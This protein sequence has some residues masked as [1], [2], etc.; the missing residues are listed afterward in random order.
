METVELILYKLRPNS[1]GGGYMPTR[2]RRLYAKTVEVK[3]Q[4]GGGGYMPIAN[5]Y[6][7]NSDLT[8]PV[9][10]ICQQQYDGGYMPIDTLRTQT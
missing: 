6:S 4:Q 10:V 8:V 1:P 9:E 3:C 2:R 5:R 7:K